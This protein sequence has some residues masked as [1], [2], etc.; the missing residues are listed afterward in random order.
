MV[1]NI[2]WILHIAPSAAF[3]I[4][5]SIPHYPQVKNDFESSFHLVDT[6]ILCSDSTTKDL[7]SAI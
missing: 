1:F 7:F 6:N 4:H 5:L 2:L 3:L